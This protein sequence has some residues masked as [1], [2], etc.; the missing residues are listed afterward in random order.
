[1]VWHPTQMVQEFGELFAW[2]LRKEEPSWQ[3]IS[4][5]FQWSLEEEPYFPTVLTMLV[6]EFEE[7]FAWKLWKEEPSWQPI[8]SYLQWSLEE[9]PYFPKVLTMLLLPLRAW[10]HCLY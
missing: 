9:E 7:L 3:P 1:M 10:K 4:S 6:Q 8:S 5:Y 2:K